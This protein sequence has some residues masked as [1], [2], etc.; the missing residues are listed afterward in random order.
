MNFLIDKKEKGFTRT[1]NSTKFGILNFLK[2]KKNSQ[3]QTNLDSRNLVGG[4]TLIE[5]MI[6][7][8][9]FTV[10][11]IIGITA[12]LNVNNT[13]R[14]SRTMRSAIDNLSFIMEDMARNIRLGSRYRC[15]NNITSDIDGTVI[16]DPL[17]SAGGGNCLGIAFEPF[18][19]PVLG[20]SND[21]VVY[22]LDIEN[23]SIFKSLDGGTTDFLPMNSV[24]IQIDEVTSG[25]T[26][27]G[28]QSNIDGEQP[29]VLIILNGTVNV[30]GSSSSFNLQT[31]VSQRLLDY[32]PTP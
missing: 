6:S 11:M 22:F 30:G 8:G 1:L 5:V 23:Q 16:E 29:S 18:W 32:P 24:D 31:T 19:N 20:D 25:F 17:D 15:I 4:F 28:A 9:L 27:F 2:N 7:I 14:K 21:Q 3:S 13:Y 10:I 12:I 26:V